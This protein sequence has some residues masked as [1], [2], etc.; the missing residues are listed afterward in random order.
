MLK[1]LGKAFYARDTI[2]VAKDLLGKYLIK[3]GLVGKIVETEAYI[4]TED[5]A[6]HG[7]WRKKET[8]APMWGP[9]GFSYVYFTYGMY[10]MLNIVSEK[11]GFPAAV[12]IRAVE[13][14]EGIEKM[15]KNRGYKASEI[16]NL[17]VL[18]NLT[19]GPGKLTQAFNIKKA[20]NNLDLT[21]NPHFYIAKSSKKESFEIVKTT[22]IGINY[23]EEYTHK[24][25]RFYIKNNPFVSKF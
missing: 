9:A 23:A 6:C 21:K 14:V 20:D 5:K 2:T 12:L 10:F 25:W 13:P 15:A 16:G 1:P 17:K 7:N 19:S 8:C 11:D 18:K 4:G 3:D 22:R 24:P